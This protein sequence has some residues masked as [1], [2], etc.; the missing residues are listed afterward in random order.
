MKEEKKT[1]K[2]VQGVIAL[3]HQE[4]L[5]SRQCIMSVIEAVVCM[6]CENMV[7]LSQ[8]GEYL[9]YFP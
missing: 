1:S 2:R 9:C 7:P 4:C 8:E 3:P 6:A 5:M